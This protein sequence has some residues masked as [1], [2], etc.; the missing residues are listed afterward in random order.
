MRLSH[1][2][3]F[4]IRQQCQVVHLEPRPLAKT[5]YLSQLEAWYVRAGYLR[6]PEYP[7]LMEKFF[8][9]QAQA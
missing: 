8:P 6:S 7:V 2:E 1:A 4:A 3:A 5:P 9:I